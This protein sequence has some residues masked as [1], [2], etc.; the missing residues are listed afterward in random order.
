MRHLLIMLSLFYGFGCSQSTILEAPNVILILTDDQG[1]G[2]LH[3]HGNDSIHTPNLDRLAKQSVRL[4]NFHVS[5][6]CAPTRASLLTGRYHLRTGTSWVTHRKEV[7]RSEEYTMAEAFRDNGYHTALFGKWHNGAQYPNDPKGQGFEH[8][9]GFKAGHWNN[10]FDT[11]LDS[12]GIQ[13]KTEGYITDVLTNNS[14]E[15]LEL[16]KDKPFFCLLSYNAPHSPFQVPDSYYD[17]YRE[18]GLTP[19]NATVYGMVENLDRNLGRLLDYLDESG[20]RQ[21]T[22]LIFLTDNGPNG[23]RYNGGMRGRKA[24]VYEGGTRVP[25]FISWPQQLPND[26][27]RTFLSAHIDLLPTLAS[28]CQ[29][30]LPNSLKLDGIDLSQNIKQENQTPVSREFFTIF[31][32]GKE[33]SYPGAI[34]TGRYKLVFNRQNESELYDLQQDPAE[35]TPLE[36]SQLEQKLRKRYLD[37]YTSVRPDSYQAP[38]I[39]VMSSSTMCT[40]EEGELQGPLSF[41]GG[42]G[43]ANDYA[44]NWAS[45]RAGIHWELDVAQAGS[46]EIKLHY[47]AKAN[48]PEAQLSLHHGDSEQSV[49]S[50]SAYYQDFP[51]ST[52]RVTR[53]E[54]YEHY[55]KEVSIGSIELPAGRQQIKIRQ[56]GND[57]LPLAVKGVSLNKEN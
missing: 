24:Q 38:P 44:I 54:V 21:N 43:W 9:F 56:I 12:N 33:Q 14:L 5:P 46:Y 51:N 17:R 13:V 40:A 8:F 32:G 42:F 30:A 6:V 15:F 47:F 34:N 31:N 11:T 49:N 36:D 16:Q 28:F 41:K 37:W 26:Q 19:K 2:D 50:L 4:T 27:D 53:G 25:M 48:I 18:A 20:L 3:F 23:E 29:L 35:Q 52:D 22:L 57:S 55:W 39:P 7:M 45:Q 1:W 10:Y